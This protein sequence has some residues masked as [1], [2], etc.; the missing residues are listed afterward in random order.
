MTADL[1]IEVCGMFKFYSKVH[2]NSVTMAQI[3]QHGALEPWST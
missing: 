1:V 3:K 2:T